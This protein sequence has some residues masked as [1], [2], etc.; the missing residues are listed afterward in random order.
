MWFYKGATSFC[1]VYG[2]LEKGSCPVTVG[3]KLQRA[4]IPRSC[5]CWQLTDMEGRHFVASKYNQCR[6]L[7]RLWNEALRLSG[8]ESAP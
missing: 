3:L 2:I 5:V 6:N 7:E 8:K 4:P 1:E